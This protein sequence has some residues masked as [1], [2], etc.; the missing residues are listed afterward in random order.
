MCE[1]KRR[2]QQ[3]NEPG[4]RIGLQAF[5]RFYERNAS[6]PKRKTYADFVKSNYYKAFVKFGWHCHSLRAINVPGYI[7]FLIDE[8]VRLD[9]WAK[10]RFY[11]KFLVKML[12]T[13]HPQ[14]ALTRSIQEINNWIEERDEDISNFFRL[15]PNT[16]LVSMISN[17]RISPWCLYNCSH[18]IEKLE[19]FNEE[20]VSLTYIWIDPEFWQDKFRKYPEDV[21]WAK[22][23][24]QE[25]GYN[26]P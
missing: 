12:K 17:G 5:V 9:W 22:D 6:T 11:E 10:D 21:K 20:Q 23:I 8:Q 25:A 4:V 3:E 26:E 19:S 2:W 1:Q 16:V 15:V 18:G 14:D 13:E 24:L 7:D